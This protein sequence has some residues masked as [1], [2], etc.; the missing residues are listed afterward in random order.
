MGIDTDRPHRTPPSAGPMALT[1][2][3]AAC[4]APFTFPMSFRGALELTCAQEMG[5]FLKS[6]I[7]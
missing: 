4:E 6:W 3:A 5:R 1:K 2:E 7:N